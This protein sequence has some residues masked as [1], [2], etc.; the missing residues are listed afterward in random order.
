[1]SKSK[2]N[3]RQLKKISKIAM[4][5]VIDYNDIVE[6]SDFGFCKEDGI[7]FRYSSDWYGECNEETSIDILS[8]DF[9]NEWDFMTGAL[10]EEEW[11]PSHRYLHEYYSISFA[12]RVHYMIKFLEGG[13]V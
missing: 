7:Y 1:M 13:H 9:A 6:L 8:L 12:N 10:F 2:L 5:A 11:D 4:L 3:K